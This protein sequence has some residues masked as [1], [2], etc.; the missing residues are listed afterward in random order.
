MLRSHRRNLSVTHHDLASRAAEAENHPK[1]RNDPK[2]AQDMAQGEHSHLN[3]TK[4]E[5]MQELPT[6]LRAGEIFR[7]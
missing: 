6:E 2:P 1:E 7:K 3:P 4:G 5:E